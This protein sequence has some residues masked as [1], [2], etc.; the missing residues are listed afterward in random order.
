MNKSVRYYLISLLV[1]ISVLSLTVYSVTA[2]TGLVLEGEDGTVVYGRTQEWSGFDTHTEAAVY[3]RGVAFQGTTP[4]GKN[5]LKWEGKYGFLGFLLLDRVI[6]DGMNEKGL[7]IGQFYH[8]GFAEYTE[9]DPAFADKS[10]SSTDVLQYVLS[11]FSTISEV[12]GGMKEVRVVPVVD[13]AINKPAPV[14]FLVVDSSGDSLVIEYLNGEPKF[15]NNPVGVITNNPTFD[16]HLQNLRNYGFLT[17]KPFEDKTW[18]DLK[19][20]PLASGSGLLGLPGDYTAPSRFVRAVVL[21]EISYPTKGGMDTV[22]QFFRIMDSFNVPASQG[23]GGRT[24]DTKIP[25]DTQWTVAHD[26]TNLITYY[27]TMFSRR[28]RKIDLYKIDFEKE[29]IRK[30]PLDENRAQ[31]VKDVTKGLR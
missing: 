16:W 27:H 26:T 24:E 5:G 11:N 2:C 20:T 15:Y 21:K 9:Y 31:D 18:V 25:S 3:P 29:G 17:I 8:E 14:H 28:V 12:R 30:I 13:T 23:E 7:T 6:N 10:I 4:D 22:N 1:L 19:I